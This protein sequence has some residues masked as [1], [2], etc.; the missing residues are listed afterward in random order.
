ML[1]NTR[2][3]QLINAFESLTRA[4]V[5]DCFE[6]E[7]SLNFLVKKGD[8]GKAIGKNGANIANVRSKLGKRIMVF[9]DDQPARA[10]IERVCPVKASPYIND[11]SVRIDVPRGERENISGREIRIIKELIKRKLDVS[12]V[13]FS[14]V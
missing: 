13:D 1:L 5:L 9:E 12:Q 14:F 4:R 8:L 3:I 7:G 2:D 10:F 6:V 11:D